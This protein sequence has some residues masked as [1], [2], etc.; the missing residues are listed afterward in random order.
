MS[1]PESTETRW[2]LRHSEQSE[3]GGKVPEWLRVIQVG[4]KIRS[5]SKGVKAGTTSSRIPRLPFEGCLWHHRHHTASTSF[6]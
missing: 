1:L 4:I 2:N 3:R 6:L 5:L